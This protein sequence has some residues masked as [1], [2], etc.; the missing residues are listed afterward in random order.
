ML[1]IFGVGPFELMILLVIVLVPVV[2]L[3]AVRL[4]SSKHLPPQ[5]NYDLRPCPNCQRPIPADMI[6]C[7]YCGTPLAV[8]PAPGQMPP[9]QPTAPPDQG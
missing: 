1:A 4:S 5:A 3:V 2:V 7:G 6:Y 8:Q 9:S